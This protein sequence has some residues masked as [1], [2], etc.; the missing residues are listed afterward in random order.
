MGGKGS[1]G[2]NKLSDAE[3]LRRGT[4]EARHSE[5]ASESRAAGVLLTGPWLTSIPAPTYKLGKA[6]K[7]LY[8]DLTKE[9]FEQNKLTKI[10]HLQ[11][12]LA[13][14]LHQK[15]DALASAGKSPSANDFAKLQSALRDLKV[16][17]NAT[18]TAS[19]GQRNKFAGSG[20]A[21]NRHA[22]VTLL[23][24]AKAPT[25]DPGRY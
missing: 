25:R 4:F 12:S 21:N 8:D 17:E 3:K 10:T 14:L 7:S 18:V 9:L 2:H 24:P 23:G 19:P 1:G 5:A 6:G 15:I 22:T 20:F 11:A 16:A 13:A